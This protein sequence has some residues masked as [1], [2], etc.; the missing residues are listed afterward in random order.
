MLRRLPQPLQWSLLVILSCGLCLLASPSVASTQESGQAL[1]RDGRYGEAAQVWRHLAQQAHNPTEAALAWNFLAVAEQ[2]LS[3]W[4]SAQRALDRGLQLLQ[5]RP[6]TP[7]ILSI[8][9][10]LLNTSG[11]QAL[12]AGLPQ[13]ALQVWRQASTLYQRLG[14]NTGELGS[15]M[16]QALALQS[17][18]FYLRSQQLLEDLQTQLQHQP[19]DLKVLGLSQL[20]TM[21]RLTG[22]LPAAQEM[23]EQ[24]LEQ[25]E[26]AQQGSIRL[27]LGHVLQDLQ[28]PEAALA[29]YQQVARQPSPPQI[30]LQAQLHQLQILIEQSPAAAI[31]LVVPLQHQLR[32]LHPS[33]SGVL[34]RV[35]FAEGLMQLHSQGVGTTSPVDLLPQAAKQLTLAIEQAHRLGDRRAEAFALG[36]MGTLQERRG[37]WSIA[38]AWTQKALQLATGLNDQDLIARWRWQQG[39]LLK[40]QGK[41]APAIDAYG[42]ALASLQNLRQDLVAIGPEIQFSFTQSVE[43]VYRELVQL[44][45]TPDSGQKMPKQEQLQQARQVLEGLKLAELDNFFRRACITGEAKSIDNLDPQA[46]VIYPIILPDRLAVILARPQQPLQYYETLLP[47]AEVLATIQQLRRYLNPVFLDETRLQLS[48]TL[49]QWLLGPVQAELA[50]QT[51]NTLVFILDG[52]LKGLPMTALHDGQAYLIESY[53]VAVAPSLELIDPQQLPRQS[54]QVLAAGLSE[55]RFDFPALPA[56]ETELQYIQQQ[57]PTNLLKNQAF[58]RTAL[59]EVTDQSFPV[60]HLATHGQFG[61]TTEDTFLVTWDGLMNAED[62]G[63]LIER[64]TN[65][66]SQP[67][68]LLILS[69][70][71]TATGDNLSALG[72][73]GIAVRS[74]ARSTIGTLWQVGD[75]STAIAMARFYEELSHTN[76]SKA[77]ALRQAQLSLLHNPAFQHPFYWAPYVLIGNWL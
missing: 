54:L 74:G 58:T 23:L 69:A 29:Q 22:N 71:Q 6:E 39:R 36:T 9:A 48:Q 46:A 18:G 2:H 1:L 45:L 14:D 24:A 62:L 70:C 55:S 11:Q 68:E 77:E 31:D 63:Q 64:A 53:S 21:Y 5:S 17:L 25:A 72:L 65:L 30:R 3:H 4:E 41:I 37:Q 52:P 27:S 76:L 42:A 57:V 26:P 61:S 15:Q 60:L 13:R 35:S 38:Q 67:V 43:P 20:G 34:A 40:Q 33:R 49:Y 32:H 10:R 50:S 66:A 16:N 8:Q 59:E 19:V 7:Q 51:V 56:V 73:S 12:A 44:L 28:K 47:Q 75:R